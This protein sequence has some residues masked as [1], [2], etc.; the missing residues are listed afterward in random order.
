VFCE[1]NCCF[2]SDEGCELDECLPSGVASPGLS[3][4]H[5]IV[6][7]KTPTAHMSAAVP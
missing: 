5:R 2:P 7:M 1:G 4:P 6:N 3:P